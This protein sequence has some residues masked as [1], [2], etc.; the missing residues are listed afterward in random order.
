MAAVIQTNTA[1]MQTGGVLGHKRK[2]EEV[3]VEKIQKVCACVCS[4]VACGE[5][6][7]TGPSN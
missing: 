1:Q 6:E 5:H 3:H 4:Y 7:Y 2:A